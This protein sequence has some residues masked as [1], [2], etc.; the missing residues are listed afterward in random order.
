MKKLKFALIIAIFTLFAWSCKQL[1][2]AL[3]PQDIATETSDA[4]LQGMG[5]GLLGEVPTNFVTDPPIAED[6]IVQKLER[7]DANGNNILFQAVFDKENPRL[8]GITTFVVQPSEGTKVLLR[9]DGKEGDEVADDRIFSAF[10]KDEPT[11]LTEIFNIKNKT[12]ERNNQILTFFSGRSVVKEKVKPIDIETFIN[13]EAIAIGG[14]IANATVEPSVFDQLKGNSLVITDLAVVQDPTRTFNPC[15]ATG[16]VNG[17]WTFKSLMTNIAIQGATP[18]LTSVNADAFV[19]NWVDTELFGQKSLANGDI[20]TPPV[21]DNLTNAASPKRKFI[22]A[23]LKNSSPTTPV[24]Q[25]NINNWKTLLVNKLQFFPVRLLAIVNRL[26]LRGNFGYA[27]GTT[28]AGEGRFVFCFMDS[29]DNCNSF[30]NGPGTLTIILEYGIP[31]S[32]CGALKTYAQ[33]WYKLKDL[34]LGTGIYNK[35]LQNV[36]NVFTKINADPSRPTNNNSALNHLRSNEFI[37]VPWNI[38]D[39]K[40]NGNTG[41]LNLIHPDLEPRNEAN[42]NTPLA[43]FVNSTPAIA[44]DGIYAIPDAIKGVDAQ[45]PSPFLFWNGLAITNDLARHKLSLNTC[46]GCHAGETKNI[47]THIKPANFGFQASLSSFITGLG[48]DDDNGDIDTDPMGTFTVKDPANRP[49]AS[50]T[51]RGFNELLRR[52]NDLE[53]LI[54]TACGSKGNVIALAELLRFQPI[55]TTD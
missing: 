19:I 18:A 40:I 42:N 6:F 12:I 35:A 27:G 41:Q 24:T 8:K 32:S 37:M 55:N 23:W 14:G 54:N 3:I 39:F 26:D 21:R 7:P 20:T 2:N 25:V 47:F 49:S 44:S 15:S 43:I 53:T 33:Q 34:T 38:R 36:T 30:N 5:G 46:S 16:A 11:T 10:I 29:N 51:L 22:A 13:G 1:S 4:V 45:I 48:N 9:D 50:P 31:I 52:A 17:V 28:N